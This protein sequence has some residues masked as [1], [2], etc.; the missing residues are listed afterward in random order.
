MRTSRA[1]ILLLATML[2]SPALRAD[3]S[4]APR[5]DAS[6]ENDTFLVEYDAGTG[7]FALYVQGMKVV[8]GD[9]FWNAFGVMQQGPAA[10]PARVERPDESTML[11]TTPV[12]QGASVRR[13]RLLEE[14]GRPVCRIEWDMTSAVTMASAAGSY[15]E[16]GL[17][18]TPFLEDCPFAADLAP[19]GEASAQGVLGQTC[20]GLKQPVRRLTV[21]T[22]LGRLTFDLASR[23]VRE[24]AA[25]ST[26]WQSHVARIAGDPLGQ[27]YTFLDQFLFQN[28]DWDQRIAGATT[29]RLVNG[30]AI[31]PGDR[32]FLGCD[33]VFDREGR[34]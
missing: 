16:I 26:A 19:P 25:N 15:A 14:E 30:Y 18:L 12:A 20:R 21:T 11:L 1:L 10:K 22:G 24:R 33:I 23:V 6:I 27:W 2:W 29:W 13:L 3:A 7:S 4:P 31:Q 9:Y 17:W 28:G 5:G 8:K 34:R 32:V